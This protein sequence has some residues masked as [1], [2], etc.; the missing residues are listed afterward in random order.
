M[1]YTTD[2][3]LDC[4][5][6]TGRWVLEDGTEL[7]AV[8]RELQAIDPATA[9]A[10]LEAERVAAAARAMTLVDRVREVVCECAFLFVDGREWEDLERLA[11]A[12][13]AYLVVTSP[14]A[15]RGESEL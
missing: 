12:V 9:T 2:T 14:Y 15:A 13:R 5:Y 6:S 1:N 11:S 10:V 4:N 8:W 3:D 7:A